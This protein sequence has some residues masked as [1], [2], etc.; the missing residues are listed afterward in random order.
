VQRDNA[1]S[2]AMVTRDGFHLVGEQLDEVDGP[3]LVFEKV[4]TVAS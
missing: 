2:L 1:A 4:L 3:E